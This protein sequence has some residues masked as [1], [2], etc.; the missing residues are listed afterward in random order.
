M[1]LS[2][3]FAKGD[4]SGF[5]ALLA[6]NLANIVIIAGVCKGVFRMPDE[7][8]FG[9]IVP[10]IGVALLAGTAA[11]AWMA[12]KLAEKEKRDDVTALPYGISTPVM[13]V[14]L[15]GVIGP[16]YFKT[17]DPVA[18][19]QCGIAAAFIGGLV[20]LAGGLAGPWIKRHTPRAGMLGTLAG[21]A[22][23]WIATIPFAEI[24][25]QPLVGFISFSIILLGLVAGVRL[26]F[27]LPAGLAAIV[28]G[29]AVAMATGLSRISAEGIG[30]HPP[31]LMP[32]DLLAGLKLVLGNPAIIAVILPI[33]IY[34]FI[35]TMN[36]V[37]SAEAAGDRYPVRRTQVI[38]GLGT[39]VGGLFGSPF[40]TT[41]YIGHPAYK[42]LGSRSG[43]A[44][45]VG[46]VLFLAAVAGLVNFLYG[47]IPVAAVAPILVFVA[48]IIGA[49]AYICVKPSHT[50]AV[51][52]ALVPHVADLVYKQVSGAISGV[53][54]YAASLAGAGEAGGFLAGL[55]SGPVPRALKDHLLAAGGLHLE[56]L[57]A[58][59]QGA[60]ISGLLWGAI[61]ASLIDCRYKAAAWFSAAAAALAGAGFIHAA[62]AG[63]RLDS[64]FFRSY[65]FMAVFFAVCAR[66]GLKCHLD[67]FS[68]MMLGKGESC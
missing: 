21:I 30:L 35:E 33:E 13:F 61:C 64:P 1:K 51:S 60:I 41:V 22:I 44:L 49:Q 18:A 23:V 55:A 54:G 12:L 43:Y 57:A 67:D 50:L 52:I 37:E 25:E 11:Y 24:M 31:L 63:P 36:N 39:I 5:W 48:M 19:W 56:G 14:Y 45:A 3:L 29:T 10:G 28:A 40:P 8:V 68:E 32:A 46:A 53:G 2:R 66:L 7:V 62:A 58:L 6:D 34:N 20:E 26:P 15:F 59:S 17:G 9:R 65:L 47:L 27:G 38:D 4:F 42:R 16:V